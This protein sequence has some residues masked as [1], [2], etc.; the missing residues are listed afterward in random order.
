[1]KPLIL[2]GL[3]VWAAMSFA[4]AAGLP[5]KPSIT[6]DDLKAALADANAQVPPDT[7]HAQCWAALIP[8]V[9]NYQ[10]VSILPTRPG[11]ALLA[12]KTFDLQQAAGKPL[13]PDAV[14]TAC[15]LTVSDL[16]LDV[17]KLAGLLG[18]Q[19]LILP[20]LPL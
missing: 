10:A 16:K 1:M 2:A 14:V 20:K 6:V 5:P 15:A 4:R 3:F 13:I 12:Q 17:A 11:L 8:F 19:A 18:V 7:R 9:E